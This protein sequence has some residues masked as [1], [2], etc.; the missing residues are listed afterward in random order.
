MPTSR[1]MVFY[2]YEQQFGFQKNHSTDHAILHL[3]DQLSKSFEKGQYTL[4]VFIDL[5]KAFD[6][7]NHSILLDKLKYYGISGIYWKWFQSYLE[8]RVQYVPFDSDS[9][10]PLLPITYGVPQ[11]SILGPLLFNIF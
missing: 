11:G 4:G 10:T 8:N 3:V 7:V 9:K 2:I 6:T 1:Q 5:S